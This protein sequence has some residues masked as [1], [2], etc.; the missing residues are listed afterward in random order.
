L[1]QFIFLILFFAVYV[2]DLIFG[3]DSFG[4]SKEN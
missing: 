3:S 4:L 2:T 1:W